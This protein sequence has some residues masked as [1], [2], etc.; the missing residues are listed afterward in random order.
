MIQFKIRCS[1]IGKIMTNPRSKSEFLSQTTMTYVQTWLKELLYSRKYEFSNKYTE[2]GTINEDESLDFIAEN[3]GYPF[4]IKN[5][6]FLSD[7][8]MTGTPDVI[9]PDHLI[10]VKNSWDC[11]TFPLF[12]STPDKN[13]WWQGQG[14]MALTGLSKYKLIYTLT[15]TPMHLIEREAYQHCMRNGYDELDE[16]VFQD[17]VQK[18]TYDEIPAKHRIKVFEFERDEEAIAAIRERVQQCNVY[19]QELINS[20]DYVIA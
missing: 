14:Y 8:H 1:A 18:M 10:D 20:G 19:L 3:L 16:D 11:F 15:N 17:F 12:E 7:E 9:L 5:E 2:K 13:Y 4:L 6:K